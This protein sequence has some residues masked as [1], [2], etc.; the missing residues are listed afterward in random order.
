MP[1]ILAPDA[2]DP[3]LDP[4]TPEEALTDL[5]APYPEDGIEAYPVSRFVNSPSNNEPRCIE[6]V[7]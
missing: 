1:V 6:S 3:W 2:Y 4:D 5:L 7:A